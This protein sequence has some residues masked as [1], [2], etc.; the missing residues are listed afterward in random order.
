MF[1]IALNPRRNYVKILVSKPLGLPLVST[2]LPRDYTEVM[3]I[4][5]E[6]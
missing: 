2:D 1:I 5:D 6:K 4:V 3:D